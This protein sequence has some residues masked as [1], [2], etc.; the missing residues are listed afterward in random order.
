MP[1]WSF[2]VAVNVAL[3]PF[4]TVAVVLSTSIVVGTG[5][6]TPPPSPTVTFALPNF[7][8]SAVDVAFTVNSSPSAA[9]AGIVNV[10]VPAVSLT[11]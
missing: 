1:F 8:V 3:P 5:I 10:N 9:F 7:V 2:T 4:F 11:V 6:T